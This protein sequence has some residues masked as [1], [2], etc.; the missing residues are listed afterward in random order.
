MCN[1]MRSHLHAKTEELAQCT[2]ELDAA[3]AQNRETQLVLKA[4]HHENAEMK[5]STEKMKVEGCE[6]KKRI[7]AQQRQLEEMDAK[8]LDATRAVMCQRGRNSANESR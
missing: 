5:K 3:V 1:E 6:A 4:L 2:T 7:T 8:M